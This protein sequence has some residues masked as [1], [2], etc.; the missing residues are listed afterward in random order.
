MTLRWTAP[1][2]DGKCGRA[3]TYRVL[4]DGRPAPIAAPPPQAAGRVETL[5]LAA[6]SGLVTVQAVDGAGNAGIPCGVHGTGP[7]VCG[8][9]LAAVAA[10]SDR[11]VLAVT[12][13][14]STAAGL[15]AVAM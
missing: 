6:T 4:I 5:S 2:G 3:S 8:L 10:A 11:R 13:R 12:G 1:G 14:A 15:A 7:A 9:R